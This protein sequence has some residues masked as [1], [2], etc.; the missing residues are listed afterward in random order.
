[1]A[2][3]L[4]TEEI[5]RTPDLEVAHRD[6]EA[7]AEL[8]VVRERGESRSRF[9]GQLGH[10]GIEE[11]RVGRQVGS[12]D[13]APD[14]VQLR[15]AQLIGA[16]DDQCV[17]LRN[18][19]TGFDDRRRD[20]HVSVAAQERVHLLLELALAHLSV[21]DEEAQLRCE[22]TKLLRRLVDRLDAVV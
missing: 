15:Q 7:G 13:P 17:G 12:A 8:G 6:R 21:R 19:E 11:I 5:P 16:L 2:G 10:V 3:L 20:E 22:L 4:V 9:R 1:V 18:V 14:L